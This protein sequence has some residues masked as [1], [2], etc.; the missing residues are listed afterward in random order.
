MRVGFVV[1]VCGLILGCTPAGDELL[2]NVS[3]IY[4]FNQKYIRY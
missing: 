4:R 1:I 3:L 2:W